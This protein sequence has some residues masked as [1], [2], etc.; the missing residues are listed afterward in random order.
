M[1][2]TLDEFPPEVSKG[3]DAQWVLVISPKA[4]AIIACTQELRE[5]PTIT[6]HKG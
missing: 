5:T 1:N 4:E 3:I 6:Y 2:T